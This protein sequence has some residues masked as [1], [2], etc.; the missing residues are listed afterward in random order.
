MSA[1]CRNDGGKERK[2]KNEP[3]GVSSMESH[4]EDVFIQTSSSERRVFDLRPTIDREG[5]DTSTGSLSLSLLHPNACDASVP[6][7]TATAPPPVAAATTVV[8]SSSATALNL[9]DVTV[10]L[11]FARAQ[12]DNLRTENTLLHE[13]LARTST[14]QPQLPPRRPDASRLKVTF[15]Q[16]SD[17]PPL[18]R[19]A[20]AETSDSSGSCDASVDT[21]HTSA[22]SYVGWSGRAATVGGGSSSSSRGSSGGDGASPP[23][24]SEASSPT[25]SDSTPSSAYSSS[26]QSYLD[27]DA[28]GAASGTSSSTR[29]VYNAPG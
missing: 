29:C 7:K 12:I 2:N 9:D 6:A 19:A 3:T 23:S 18:A 10:M 16:L 17:S 24:A 4:H 8:S 11:G 15:A 21:R 27:D 28:S 13:T 14:D 22:S 26:C 20:P 1:F 5:C 25:S